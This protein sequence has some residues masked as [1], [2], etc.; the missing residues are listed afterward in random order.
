MTS[1]TI[2]KIKSIEELLGVWKVIFAQIGQYI[3][4]V[5]RHVE[6]LKRYFPDNRHLMLLAE[7]DG[8]IVG[9]AIGHGNTL[10]A[11]AIVPEHR[12]RGLGRRMMHVFEYSAMMH[13]LPM[14]CL[15]ADPENKAFYTRLGYRGKKKSMMKEF[16]LPGRVLDLRLQKLGVAIGDLDFGHVVIVEPDESIPALRSTL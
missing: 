14:V 4:D 15:G 11:I 8:R 7:S 3:T 10:H 5:D 1:Y 6:D 13:G 16:P 9:G 2:R 12:G